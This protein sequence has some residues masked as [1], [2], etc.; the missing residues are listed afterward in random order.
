MGD[1]LIQVL[2]NL[3]DNAIKFSHPNSEINISV[4]STEEKLAFVVSDSGIGFDPKYSEELFK[5]FTN[6]SRLGTAN[7]PSTGIGL[8]LCKKIVEKYEGQLLSKSEGVGKGANFFVFFE[9]VS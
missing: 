5:K 2:V 8:Y 1:L 4:A 6:I 7:E 9:K 3:I